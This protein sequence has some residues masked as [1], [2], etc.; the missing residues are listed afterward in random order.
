MNDFFNFDEINEKLNF[1]NNEQTKTLA[2]WIY[3]LPPYQFTTT[4]FL[5]GM[6]LSQSLNFHEQIAVGNFLIEIGQ[7]ILTINSRLGI[8]AENQSLS[9]SQSNDLIQET[10]SEFNKKLAIL[11]KQ[12]NNIKSSK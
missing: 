6:L 11:Q 7:V 3:S 12:I 4:A 2:K 8:E 5:I 1:V 9:I 10:K